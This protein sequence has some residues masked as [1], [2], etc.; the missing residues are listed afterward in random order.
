MFN[1]H[2]S[3]HKILWRE[4]NIKVMFKNHKAFL[5]FICLLFSFPL[6]AKTYLRVTVENV[7]NAIVTID[8]KNKGEQP[9]YCEVTSGSHIV[10]VN[11]TAGYNL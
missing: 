5:I 1:N 3:V 4:F 9:V 6:F 8:G 10:Q 7:P 2:S 11:K